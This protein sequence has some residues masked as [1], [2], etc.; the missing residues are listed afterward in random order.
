MNYYEKKEMN[1]GSAFEFWSGYY[2]SR[3][4]F[5]KQIKDASSQ[6]YS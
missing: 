5:K 4:G 1:A 3:P 6:Y 2:T